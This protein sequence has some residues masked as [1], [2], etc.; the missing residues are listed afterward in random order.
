MLLVQN[1]VD[2]PD[3]LEDLSR[4][5]LFDLFERPPKSGKIPFSRILSSSAI[6]SFT[7]EV[8]PENP[9]HTKSLEYLCQMMAY[10]PWEVTEDDLPASIIRTAEEQARL[11]ISEVTLLHLKAVIDEQLSADFLSEPMQMIRPALEN[12]STKINQY[13]LQKKSLPLLEALHQMVSTSRTN[14]QA[15]WISANADEIVAWPKAQLRPKAFA[16]CSQL[17]RDLLNPDWEKNVRALKHIKENL[18]KNKD[19]VPHLLFLLSQLNAIAV[20]S[21]GTNAHNLDAVL[22]PERLRLGHHF[23]LSAEVKS[24]LWDVVE[25][26]NYE[27]SDSH[28][29]RHRVKLTHFST[30]FNDHGIM[31]IRNI[32]STFHR[33]CVNTG[34]LT[35]HQQFQWCREPEHA[36]L[37]STRTLAEHTHDVG[38]LPWLEGTT[39][40]SAFYQLGKSAA[41]MHKFNKPQ[42]PLLISLEMI[43]DRERHLNPHD[44]AQEKILRLLGCTKELM[45]QYQRFPDSQAAEADDVFKRRLDKT[46]MRLAGH[47]EVFRQDASTKSLNSA[48]NEAHQALT[49]MRGRLFAYRVFK[50]SEPLAPAKQFDQ[51]VETIKS[52]ITATRGRYEE[53]KLKEEHL[54]ALADFASLTFTANLETTPIGHRLH[55]QEKHEAICHEGIN[56]SQ[57]MA[58]ACNL[59]EAN[60]TVDG[61]DCGYMIPQAYAGL[62]SDNLYNYIHGKLDGDLDGTEGEMERAYWTAFG[63]SKTLRHGTMAHMHT[64]LNGEGQTGPQ[65]VLAIENARQIL[66]EESIAHFTSVLRTALRGQHYS[67]HL[68]MRAIGYISADLIEAARRL[69]LNPEQKATIKEFLHI[70][71]LAVPDDIGRHADA[72]AGTTE[73]ARLRSIGDPKEQ[74][75]EPLAEEFD[76]AAG[77]SFRKAYFATKDYLDTSDRYARQLVMDEPSF[78]LA[79]CMY[80]GSDQAETPSLDQVKQ[81]RWARLLI[82]SAYE[83]ATYWQ[84][85]QINLMNG[86]RQ[87]QKELAGIWSHRAFQLQRQETLVHRIASL[88]WISQQMTSLAMRASCLGAITLSEKLLEQLNELELEN[89]SLATVFTSELHQEPLEE[90]GVGVPTQQPIR[91]HRL[92]RLNQTRATIKTA[93]DELRH[94][95]KTLIKRVPHQHSNETDYMF[96]ALDDAALFDYLSGLNQQQ[97]NDK[98]IQAALAA[99]ELS[100]TIKKSSILTMSLMHLSDL[101]TLEDSVK[102]TFDG[103]PWQKYQTLFSQH[104]QV[105]PGFLGSLQQALSYLLSLLSGFTCMKPKAEQYRLTLFSQVKNLHHDIET[106]AEEETELAPT[107]LH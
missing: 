71:Y 45:L 85:G 63:E 33:H 50:Q 101:N 74:P 12:L 98:N 35:I 25:Q 58:A 107:Q 51:S 84:A 6:D 9:E 103:I 88:R 100:G 37:Y 94:H 14:E 42:S 41:P 30:E 95:A 81:E 1:Q 106:C 80:G 105:R 24:E 20:G 91:S 56:R 13:Q 70:H 64:E 87:R 16:A 77:V 53:I 79:S 65:S 36:G 7:N 86:L 31:P 66:K 22:I 26:L 52:L 54:L 49:E 93:I 99:V 83:E 69:N 11:Q 90:T 34:G 96:S 89:S 29:K 27:Y 73:Q 4:E 39:S 47:R 38:H 75:F 40:I 15:L 21:W 18:A 55:F 46:L 72:A 57:T 76:G 17:M 2:L 97:P 3:N 10:L 82:D 32:L 67:L 61:A 48:L 104:R 60:T 68:Y 62:H 8:S 5:E 19:A 59:M 43:E 28:G 92:A 102:K 78:E 44:R 23:A